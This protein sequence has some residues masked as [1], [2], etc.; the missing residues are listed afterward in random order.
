MNCELRIIRCMIFPGIY[1]LLKQVLQNP[2][3]DK[4][5]TTCIKIKLESYIDLILYHD[6]SA[7]YTLE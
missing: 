5:F 6:K 7:Y 3:L 2:P 4:F 1:K